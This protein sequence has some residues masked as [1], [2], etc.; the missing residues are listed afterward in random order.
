[1]L[2]ASRLYV[3]SDSRPFQVSAKI[4]TCHTVRGGWASGGVV[5]RDFVN[6]RGPRSG[7][8]SA[9]GAYR[10]EV[11]PYPYCYRT[12]SVHGLVLCKSSFVS[13]SDNLV[14]GF[15]IKSSNE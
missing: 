12:D 5:A 8:D 15:H 4:V 6:G 14:D 10:P 7:R 9:I 13:E 1:M 11:H 2:L 3:R